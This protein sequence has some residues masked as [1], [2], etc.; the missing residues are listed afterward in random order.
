MS[1]LIKESLIKNVINN[2]HDAGNEILSFYK[3]YQKI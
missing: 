1:F 2:M 3:N